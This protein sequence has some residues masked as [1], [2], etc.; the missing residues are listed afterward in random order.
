VVP[1]LA[2]AGHD[3]VHVRDLG[4]AAADDRTIL[5]RARQDDRV[6]VTQDTDF[7][8]LLAAA[9]A[10][11]RTD[12]AAHGQPLRVWKWSWPLGCPG[13]L[14]GTAFAPSA[15]RSGG[16]VDRPRGPDLHGVE[17]AMRVQLGLA[18]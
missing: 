6:I 4:L 1:A 16:S 5:E 2:G 18:A 10:A 14:S 12:G 7:G 13:L 9:L 15:V 3:T 17:M 8:T 11:T